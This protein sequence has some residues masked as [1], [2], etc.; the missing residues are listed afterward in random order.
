MWSSSDD[1]GC[2][3]FCGQTLFC[4]VTR[5]SGGKFNHLLIARVPYLQ[6]EIALYYNA[7]FS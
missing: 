4:T 1:Y 5:L 7:I 3:I 6:L 2:A